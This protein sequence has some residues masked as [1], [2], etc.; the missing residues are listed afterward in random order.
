MA[1][2]G[3]DFVRGATQP[4]YLEGLFQLGQQV[5]SA[6]RRR[7][8]ENER[9]ETQETL[10]EM[11]NTNT[12]IAETGNLKGLE[13]QRTL[14]TGMLS[15]VKGDESRDMILGELNRF[16][17]LR[18]VA[19]PVARQRDINT[20]IRSEQTLKEIN[21]VVEGLKGATTTEDRIKEATAREAQR[22]IKDRITS[23]KSDPALMVAV[24]N[25][26]IDREIASLTKD[27]ALRSAR[28]NDM[29]ARL[30]STSPTSN[31]WKNLVAD[32][33]EKGL[34]KAV[35]TAIE[36]INAAELK[37]LEIVKAQEE[38]RPLSEE[39]IAEL[40][41]AKVPLSKGLSVIE[42]R[43]RYTV[44]ANSQI[45]KAVN[46]ATRPL[47]VPSEARAKALVKTTLD[48]MVRDAELEGLPFSKDLSDKVE[49]L[50]ADPEEMQTLNG[51]V[52][53]LSGAE[54]IDAV[55]GYIKDKFPEKYAEYQ[56]FRKNREFEEEEFQALLDEVYSEDS[57]LD[58][59][60]PSGVDQEKARMK[61]EEKIR[62]AIAKQQIEGGL[63]KGRLLGVN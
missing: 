58:R 22:V 60:D 34:G 42:Q 18:D 63:F 14:L 51:I 47:D 3:R 62:L 56:Q 13:E 44:F 59:N 8:E 27:E 19:K 41:E 7:R 20:L 16:E 53:D 15:N 10:A 12:R 11:I 24:D 33:K 49:D 52:A 57:S 17:A 1:R 29:L 40:R 31:E 2:F 43:R 21:D 50:L 46:K 38:Q 28:Q 23:L 61:A 25:E 5:G 35:D 54:I 4:A 9:R 37:R 55:Q 45:E 48:F 30:R 36:E 6:P 26:L 32:A 39:E